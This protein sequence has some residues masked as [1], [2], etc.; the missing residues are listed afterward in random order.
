[1]SVAALVWFFDFTRETLATF[2]HGWVRFLPWVVLAL[3]FFGTLAWRGSRK[4]LGR[5]RTRNNAD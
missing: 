3:L 5:G 2:E 1:L 4:A